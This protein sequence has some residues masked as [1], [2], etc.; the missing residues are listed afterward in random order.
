MYACVVYQTVFGFTKFM[1]TYICPGYSRFLS[2][3]ILCEIR[4]GAAQIR[5]DCAGTLAI[6]TNDASQLVTC[7]FLF[8][9]NVF[10][11]VSCL[12]GLQF[13]ERA[14]QQFIPRPLI[15]YGSEEGAN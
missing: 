3:L 6:K 1:S 12:F 7:V 5:T 10:V 15:S 8:A 4:I 2:H 13:M 11:Y 9:T 14:I